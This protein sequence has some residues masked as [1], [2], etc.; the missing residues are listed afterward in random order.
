MRPLTRCIRL[1]LL[2]A[3]LIA[4]LLLTTQSF[5]ESGCH[6]QGQPRGDVSTGR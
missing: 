4:P 3:A 5:A 1:L 2:A 6:R